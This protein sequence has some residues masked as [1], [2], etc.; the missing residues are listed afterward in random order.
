V[1]A[2]HLVLDRRHERLCEA[3]LGTEARAAA[4]EAERIGFGRAAARAGR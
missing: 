4:A 1:E 2:Q 3:R